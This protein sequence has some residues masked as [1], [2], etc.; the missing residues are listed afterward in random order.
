MNITIGAAET[1]TAEKRQYKRVQ[2][3]QPIQFRSKNDAFVGGSLA[4]DLSEGGM[5]VSLYD[6][7]PLGTELILELRMNVE[8]V[9][10]YFGRVVWVRKCAYADRYEIG[11]EFSSE[12]SFLPS[13][14]QLHEFIKVI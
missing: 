5:R 14:R 1:E 6:F 3:R 13:R 12:K 8:K 10:E 4:C 7:I 9:I 2:F 11:L